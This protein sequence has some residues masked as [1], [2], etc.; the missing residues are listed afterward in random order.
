MLPLAAIASGY[1]DRV[2][3]IDGRPQV[4]PVLALA[5]S[6]D[7]RILDGHTLAAFVTQVA[8]LLEEPLL[9]FEDLR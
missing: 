3:P 4:R 2:V 1:C 7:H 5:V 9:L 6:G 8:G